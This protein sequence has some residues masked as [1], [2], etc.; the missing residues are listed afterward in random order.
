[1]EMFNARRL[2]RIGVSAALYIV[3]TL[4]AAPV[5]FDAVQF[6]VSEMLMLLCFYDKDYIISLTIGCFISNLF[7]SLGMI[8]MIFGT[9]ATLLAAVCIYV[10]RKK[11]NLPVAS[12]FPVV[13]NALIVGL[14]IKI[15]AGDPFW[16]NAGFVALGE[17]TVVSVCGVIVFKLLEKN[18]RFMK[19]IT[20]D[21]ERRG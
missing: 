9:S 13:F 8:D 11:I 20:S 21:P 18:K 17:F 4:V 6:R 5:A 1:M 19:M 12:I 10:F 16:V 7:S 14:E 3:L 15:V 2:T